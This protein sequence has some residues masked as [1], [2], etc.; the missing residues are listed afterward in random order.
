LSQE[1]AQMLRD[2]GLFA[3]IKDF[4]WNSRYEEL[5]EFIETNKT[6]PSPHSTDSYEKSLGK[7]RVGQNERIRDNIITNDQLEK[8]NCLSIPLD[9]PDLDWDK[10]YKRVSAIFKKHLKSGNTFTKSSIAE[11]L[12][13]ELNDWW[14]IQ[15]QRYNDKRLSNE[16]R[17]L[18]KKSNVNYQTEP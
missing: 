18:I 3:D 9:L 2:A 14:A 11:V 7:W 4:K 17:K 10:K 16:Q 1:K 15:M 6:L 12:E 13:K 5:K 8:L